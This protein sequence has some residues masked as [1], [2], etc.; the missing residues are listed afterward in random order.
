MPGDK[1]WVIR[2]AMPDDAEAIISMHAQSWLD[3][4]PNEEAGVAR[5]WVEKNTSDWSHPE[6]TESRRQRIREALAS[7]DMLYK[8]ALDPEGRV[9]GFVCPFRDSSG[10]RVGGLYVEKSYQGSGLAQS[11]MDEAINWTDPTK[12][13]V[14]EVAA[15]NERAKRFYKKYGFKEVAGSEQLHK[16]TMPIITMI[17]KGSQ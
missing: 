5:E 17:R 8:I 14:L 12:P 4:Y 16:N 15:Y 7:P 9:I 2:D 10:Q 13:L 11:L 1:K 6:R 3:T